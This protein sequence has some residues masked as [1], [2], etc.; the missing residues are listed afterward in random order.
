MNPDQQTIQSFL[1]DLAAKTPSPGGGAVT[2]LVAAIAASLAE[3]VLAFSRNKKSLAQHAHLHDNTAQR[4]AQARAL[5]LQLAE[6]D[7]QAY[8]QLNTLLKLPPEDPTRTAQLL[9]TALQATQIPLSVM[10]AC[11][12]LL[13][14]FEQLAPASN[15]FL[16][17]D[18][19]ISAILTEAAARAA[20]WNVRANLPL[21][22]E[23]SEDAAVIL[24]MN[25]ILDPL[26][27][28]LARITSACDLAV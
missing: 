24:E 22:A 28:L 25:R 10:A 13:R 19:A 1:D 12:E 18:L 14:L 17:S 2:S 11:A 20:A 6:A 15:R 16:L 8:A 26:P 27:D 7:E 9:P 21:L 3:M 4:L 5:L 23:H